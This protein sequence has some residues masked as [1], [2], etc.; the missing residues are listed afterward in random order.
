MNTKDTSIKSWWK[1]F[2]HMNRNSAPKEGNTLA[3]TAAATAIEEEDHIFGIPLENSLQNAKAT[4]GYADDN[5]YYVGF[6]P[7]IVAK[8]GSFLKDQ[9][10]Y[11]E[12]VFRVSG[13]AK[14]IG[15]LQQ[16][17]STGPDYGRSLDWQGYSVHDA[18]TLLRR[19]LNYLPEPVIVPRLYNAFKETLGWVEGTEK[20]E[21]YQRLIEQLPINHQ[22][23]LFYLLDMIALFSLHAKATKMDA[24]NLASVFATGI[25]LDPDMSA[26]PEAY[27]ESQR[28][29]QYLIEHNHQ[30]KMPKSEWMAVPSLQQDQEPNSPKR[31]LHLS[32]RT[33]HSEKMDWSSSS[34][35]SDKNSKVKRSKT[36]PT[37]R[38]KY[39]MNDPLQ[40]IQLSKQ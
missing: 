36:M 24:A 23:L 2:T 5:V 13:S 40:V 31:H 32:T 27:K 9:G 1:R 19:Y 3:A 16:I 25:L 12:G 7:V 39:G 38:S 30:L 11:T 10:L 6:V 28:V 22:Y 17:F 4:I 20:V 35:V 18:A 37:R 15:G 33:P 26:N 8:C 21:E 14:R 29:V 34:I